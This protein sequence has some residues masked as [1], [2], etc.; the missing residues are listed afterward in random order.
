RVTID[1]NQVKSSVR[2]VLF[3]VEKIGHR[4]DL[5]K[6]EYTISYA[7]VEEASFLLNSTSSNLFTPDVVLVSSELENYTDHYLFKIKELCTKWSLFFILYSPK[8]DTIA[9]NI[10]VEFGFDDYYSGN[11]SS[12]IVKKAEFIKKLKE[13]KNKRSNKAFQLNP[14]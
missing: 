10:T 6:E 7:T 5:A 11:L 12:A 9:R 4:L 14:H 8:F 2:N 1:H 3:V 13:Y